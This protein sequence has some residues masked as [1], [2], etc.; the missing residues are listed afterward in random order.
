MI[1]SGRIKSM[2]YSSLLYRSLNKVAGYGLM[3][4]GFQWEPR[5]SGEVQ[6]GL[7]RMKFSNR[8]A[9]RRL[10]LIP[11]FGDTPL[12]WLSVL[13][14]L[15]STLRKQY[16]ELILVDF[17]GF[18][19]YL[20]TEQAFH[21]LDRMRSSLFDTLDSLKPQT[22]I[23]HSLGGYLSARYAIEYGKKT[24]PKLPSSYTGPSQL[25]LIAPSGI[26]SRPEDRVELTT[27]YRNAFTAKTDG[28][29]FIRGDIFA[30]EPLWFRLIAPEFAAFL[31]KDDIAQF[32]A[33]MEKLPELDEE[34]A[35]IRAKIALIWGARDTLIVTRSM[36]AWL[37]KLPLAS[38]ELISGAGH[39]PQLEKPRAL[40]SVIDKALLNC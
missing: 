13:G 16:D 37:E 7:W 11:G 24:R 2:R 39:S 26:F 25:I 10:V 34:V 31:A 22:L 21:S 18:G 4:A 5:R 35:H 12:S 15:G 9:N 6:L 8:K 30:K 40:A 20:S 14:L 17:P 29:R 3:R 33:S 19:G 28:L 1:K 38:G 36:G 27:K 32:A 23:G